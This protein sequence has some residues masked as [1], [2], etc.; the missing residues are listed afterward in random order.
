MDTSTL[1]FLIPKV[2]FL[3]KTA[4]Y[5]SLSLSPTA[6]KWDLRT[7]LTVRLI[8]EYFCNSVPTSISKQQTMSLKD[9]GIKGKMW[10]SKVTLPRPEEDDMRQAVVDAIEA[11]KEGKETYT[12]PELANV[13]AEW[14]GWRE[15]VGKD[16]PRPNLSEEEHYTNLTKEVSSDITILYLHGG[17][18]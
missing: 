7:E 13:E 3:L 6:S 8:R 1:S 12:L 11:L 4:L 14:T 15:G 18:H 2:P 10:I 16:A 5:H 9:P 17:G